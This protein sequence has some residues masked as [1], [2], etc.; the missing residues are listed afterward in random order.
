MYYRDGAH[1]VLA[2][3]GCI[4]SVPADCAGCNALC[5]EEARGAGLFALATAAW[6]DLKGS[7]RGQ[8]TESQEGLLYQ[9]CRPRARG[10]TKDPKGP[11]KWSI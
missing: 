11:S 4:T 2:A 6:R 9:R 1:G 7:E 8:P 5:K 10:S 3:H